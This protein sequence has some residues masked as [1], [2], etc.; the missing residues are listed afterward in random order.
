MAH[1]KSGSPG[2]F[3]DGKDRDFS[4]VVERSRVNRI[5]RDGSEIQGNRDEFEE[6]Q[7]RSVS[8][9]ILKQAVIM[10]SVQEKGIIDYDQETAVVDKRTDF[11]HQTQGILGKID[12]SLWCFREEWRIKDQQIKRTIL[13]FQRADR[14]EEITAKEIGRF[15]RE[16]I[17]DAGLFCEF[18]EGTIAVHLQDGRGTCRFRRHAETSGVGKRIQDTLSG[19]M[20]QNPFAQITRIGVEGAVP[21]HGQIDGME[22]AVF[23]DPGIGDSASDNEPVFCP[24]IGRLAFLE[25]DGANP[26]ECV[27]KGVQY[28]FD[29]GIGTVSVNDSRCSK[30][31]NGEGFV[32]FG[33]A[34][35]EPPCAD[36]IGICGEHGD[37]ALERDG[38]GL[39]AGWHHGIPDQ[40]TN[41]SLLAKT[42]SHV[43]LIPSLRS[44]ASSPGVGIW[45]LCISH[46]ASF[47]S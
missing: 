3:V 34:M 29:R 28:G 24:S 25:D 41:K 18:Q 17:Q 15:A 42:A 22:D 47:R 21:V 6:F 38:E 26:W 27:G 7:T 31:V 43:R 40:S 46:P 45:E 5:V 23:H 35:E 14:G 44:P 11:I 8:A 33:K 13:F 19:G 10:F 1:W 39:F 20:I 16:G 2:F 9:Q 12:R 37:S 4:G 36:M 30:E 32:A